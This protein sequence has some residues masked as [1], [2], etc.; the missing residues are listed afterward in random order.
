MNQ[1]QQHQAEQQQRLVAVGAAL[2]R[3]ARQRRERDGMEPPRWQT[4]EPQRA[5]QPVRR[6]A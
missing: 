2:D 3:L 4:M 5:P 1:Q 6:A